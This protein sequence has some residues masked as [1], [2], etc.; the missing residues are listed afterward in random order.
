MASEADLLRRTG[1]AEYQ[2]APSTDYSGSIV[3]ALYQIAAQLAE[4]KE[5]LRYL[6]REK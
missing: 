3:R 5:I 1:E 6:P 2:N 4:I